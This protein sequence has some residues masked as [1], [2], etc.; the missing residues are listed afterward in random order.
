MDVD[1]YSL[2]VVLSI[3]SSLAMKGGEGMVKMLVF[4]S[5]D[6]MMGVECG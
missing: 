2:S 4:A 3:V 1:S 5:L 6:E